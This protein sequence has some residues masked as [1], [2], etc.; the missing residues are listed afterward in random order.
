MKKTI[1][2]TWTCLIFFMGIIGLTSCEE[3]L[4]KS[5]QSDIDSNVPFMNYRNFQGFTELLYNGIPMPSAH[6]MHNSWN[7][8]EEDYNERGN[9]NDIFLSYHI[10]NGNY[11][12]AI[13]NS[14]RIATG[15]F[16]PGG[17]L[18]G[19]RGDGKNL[20]GVSWQA[21]RHA[22][23]GIANLDKLIS[24]TAEERNL[25]EGQLYFFRAWYH[26]MMIQYWG[27][28]PY[29]DRVLP[30]DET[31]NLPR[32]S[33]HECADKIAEDFQRAADLLPVDWD[34]TTVGRQTV[35]RNN[36]RINKIMAMAY[37]GK[38]YLWAG[39]PL[40][41]SV[42]TGSATYNVEYCKKA[43]DVFGQALALTESTGRYELADFS[44]YQ[45]LFYTYNQQNR[46]PGLKEAI[47][48]EKLSD[49]GGRWRWNQVTNYRPMMLRPN[50]I[51]VWATANYSFYYGMKNGLPITNPEVADAESGYDP[52]YPWRDRDPRFYN[53]IIYDGVQCTST[54]RQATNPQTQ[55]PEPIQYANLSSTGIYRYDQGRGVITGFMISKIVHPM[56]NQ[57]DGHEDG[58]AMV[59]S[60]MRLADVYLMYAEAA[61]I[62]YGTPQS[63]AGGY[64]LSALDAVNKIRARAGVDNVAEKF[65]GNTESFMS[66]V[67]RERAVELFYEGHRF[68]DLRRWMLLHQYPYNIKT[69]IEFDRALPDDEMDFT[70]PQEAKVLNLRFRDEPLVERQFSMRH[71]WFPLPQNDVNMYPELYQNPGW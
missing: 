13:S 6:D 33:Y 40:M 35:G 50:G 34:Q 59:L 67:R 70:K 12:H 32:L 5:P 27:G 23:I 47:F 11:W 41:N 39:S 57:W 69:S 62:G 66:E 42:S 4:D 58:N 46:L 56:A 10:D 21:I 44:Q 26:F 9:N 30:S 63:K 60:F 48:M 38:N 55:R 17:S 54:P 24:A 7:Y 16:Y 2:K 8:G 65:T 61:A 51:K 14:D 53:D 31:F 20:W 68:V 22:N 52:Q 37:L 18:S 64:S 28:L 3:Y 19:G 1:I 36:L 71:Y 29:I 45:Q 25:I 49:I 15:W 43:A